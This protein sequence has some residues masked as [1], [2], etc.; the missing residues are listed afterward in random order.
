M[1]DINIIA[2]YYAELET[3]WAEESTEEWPDDLWDD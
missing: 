2:E 3:A 1:F